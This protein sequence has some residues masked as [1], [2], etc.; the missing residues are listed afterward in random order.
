MI[1]KELQFSFEKNAQATLTV[2]MYN[3]N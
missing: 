2:S 1:N 3:S